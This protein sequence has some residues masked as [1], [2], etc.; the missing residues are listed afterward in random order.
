MTF[1]SYAQNFEDVLLWRALGHIKNGFYIDVGANSP[2]EQSV[3]KAFYDAGWSGINIE[4]MPS[5]MMAFQEHRPRDIS[6]AVAA[7]A[8]EGEITLF[9]I[10]QMNGWATVDVEV[11]RAHQ[12]DG[13]AL[14]EIKVPLRTLN[15]ICAQYVHGPIHFLK[16]DVEGF[17]G[18]VL[19]G[20]DF[21]KWRPWVVVVEATKPGS[22]VSNHETWETLV[23]AAG[24]HYAYFDGLNRYYVAHEHAELLPALT[25]QPNVF[26]DFISHHEDQARSRANELDQQVG[27]AT[28][29]VH[30]L[31]QQAREL[32]GTIEQ[33]G[34]QL[35]ELDAHSRRV[36]GELENA[37]NHILQTEA[38]LQQST[39][40]ARGLEQQL[41]AIYS[42]KSWRLMSLL[43]TITRREARPD[44]L[45]K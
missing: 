6:L 2:V 43:R 10:P 27:Q 16:I 1:V 8:N 7:G 17:E 22:R 30:D 23:T 34:R 18:E 38:R 15:V 39:E 4:P 42:S 35:V 32:A 41:Q 36:E 19:R 31:E 9:D 21:A 26:D 37:K 5:F 11:A 3:T 14:T 44:K 40:L 24:Y 29:R 25:I 33:L 45:V 13:Y 28:S 12:A 20:M